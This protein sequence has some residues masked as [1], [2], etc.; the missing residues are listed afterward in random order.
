VYAFP[1][2]TFLAFAQCVATAVVIYIMKL[3]GVVSFPD[4]DRSVLG[5]L[6]PLPIFFMLNVL[7]GL[8]GTKRINVAM[9]TVLRRFNIPITLLL[10]RILLSRG[11]NGAVKFSIFLMVLGALVAAGYDLTFDWIGVAFVLANDLFTSL[12]GVLMEKKMDAK[13]LNSWGLMFYNSVFA[14]PVMYLYIYLR[15]DELDKVTSFDDWSNLSFLLCFILAGIMGVVLQYST[16]LCTQINSALTTSVVGCLKNVLTA[17]FSIMG[18]GGDYV[19]SW[20]NFIGINISI[21]GSLVYAHQEYINRNAGK[22]GA[23]A[24]PPVVPPVAPS[25]YE[26]RINVS[27]LWEQG[28]RDRPSRT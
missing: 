16:Y 12:V 5:K 17:Y 8:G 4:F 11:S 25:E 3:A 1:S 13:E 14:I 28:A 19:F 24:P 27:P 6:F 10:N 21:I 26:A 2:F 23:K 22:A 18:L 20:M 9:F 15:E 7:S